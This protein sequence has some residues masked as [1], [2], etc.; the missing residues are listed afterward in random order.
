MTVIITIENL[1]FALDKGVV[2]NNNDATVL[3]VLCER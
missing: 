1:G 2:L 3:V